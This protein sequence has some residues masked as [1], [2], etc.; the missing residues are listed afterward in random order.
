MSQC[1][2]IIIDRGISVP[3]HGKDVVDGLNAVY[4][5]YIYQFMSTVQLPGSNI[6]DSHM[7]IHTENQRDD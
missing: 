2:F 1:Y 7:Q 5:L 6:F 4:K 3:R